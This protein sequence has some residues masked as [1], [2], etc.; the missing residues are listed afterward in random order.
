MNSWLNG[1]MT[2]MNKTDDSFASKLKQARAATGL[3]QQGM[4]DRMLIPKRTIQQWE[5]EARTPAP[6]VQR[7]VLNELEGLKI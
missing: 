7:F 6:Y 3:S 5:I 4:A 1:M 2:M